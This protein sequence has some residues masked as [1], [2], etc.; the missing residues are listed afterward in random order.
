LLNATHYDFSLT[1][2]DPHKI[3]EYAIL[4]HRWGADSDEITFKD[5][6]NNTGKSKVGYEKL[7]DRYLLYRQDKQH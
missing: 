3:P 7:L 2:F 4:S 1:K 6:E 5:V